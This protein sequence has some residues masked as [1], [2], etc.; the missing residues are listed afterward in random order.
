MEKDGT[1]YTF[2]HLFVA[3]EHFRERAPYY[4]AIIEDD[5]DLRFP[6]FIIGIGEDETVEVGKAVKFDS[7]D[8]SGQKQYTLCG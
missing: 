4:C 5:A 1:I 3:T 8:Q 6:A 7:Y 2:T